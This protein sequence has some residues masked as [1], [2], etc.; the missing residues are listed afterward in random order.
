MKQS[1]TDLHLCSTRVLRVFGLAFLIN[2]FMWACTTPSP[3][4]LCDSNDECSNGQVCINGL[5]E[6]AA[7]VPDLSPGIDC[8]Q[9]SDCG[10]NA[11]CVEGTCFQ[12]ECMDGMKRG[13]ET[14]CGTGE[15]LCSG[16]VWRACNAQPTTEIC[17]SNIDEDCD[18]Q[19]DEGCQGCQNGDERP[20]R[21]D[22]GTG[23]ERCIDGQFIGCTAGRPRS[24]ICLDPEAGVDEDCDGIIDEE[25]EMCPQEGATRTC[26]TSCGMGQEICRDGRYRDCSAQIP[27]DEV[28]NGQDDD[29]DG[30]IDEQIVRDCD[31]KCGAG[32]E[33]CINGQW[34]GC[35]A[36]ENCNCSTEEG[37]DIQLCGSC[38]ERSRICETPQW[39]EWSECL[40]GGQC[41]PGQ[42]EESTCGLC[43]TKRRLCVS[44]CEWGDWQAC[45]NEGECSPGQVEMEDC[46]SGCGQRTRTCTD[47]CG[48]GEWTGCEAQNGVCMPDEVQSE[49]CGACG[50]T[51]E[52]ICSD[53][54]QWGTWGECQNSGNVCTPGETQDQSCGA[55][56]TQTRVCSNDCIWGD[57]G[58]CQAGSCSPGDVETRECGLCG[59]Q[60]RRCT[61]Q[62]GW[63]DWE[64]CT[65]GGVCTPGE[66]VT[67]ACGTNVGACEFGTQVKSCN[68]SCQWVEGACEGGVEP[69]TE[70]CGAERDWNCDGSVDDRPDGFEPNNSCASCRLV[71]TLDP[72]NFTL[73]ATI[74]N[75]ADVDYFCFEVEDNIPIN[76]FDTNEELTIT[77]TNVP[78]SVDF[79]LYVYQSEEDCV[80]GNELASSAAGRGSDEEIIWSEPLGNDDSGTYIVKIVGFS[81]NSFSCNEFYTLTINGL[82]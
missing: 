56:Q 55:C 51:R 54:C 18:G 14:A 79:D 36:P 75:F 60:T 45:L 6:N 11:R 52:R 78:S 76:P 30:Q 1:K 64:P 71:G 13:C 4:P 9:S 58:E 10:E 74:D 65:G 44:T 39:G 61:S 34:M 31:N 42:A 67:V 21:T 5:C 70:A 12:N 53:I 47:N 38:G 62:C 17:G 24:E 69:I 23:V 27:V 46:P 48:W 41:N 57:W 25:C 66:D 49:S 28:C 43:G 50:Q 33:S 19:V 3:S 7:P 8:F 63:G 82:H 37:V 59:T 80:S 15:E 2:M 16:G 77:L 29:C 20:C 72:R 73:T 32:S 26:E 22:C 68:S 81:N 40:M 35:D